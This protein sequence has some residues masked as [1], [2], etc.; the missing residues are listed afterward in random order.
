[1]SGRYE[2]VYVKSFLNTVICL[3]DWGAKVNWAEMP[4]S[5]DLP[6]SRAKL[7]STFARA[8]Y[9]HMLMVDSDMGWAAED[10][11]RLLMLKREFV[12]GIGPKKTNPLEPQQ[13]AFSMGAAVFGQ[14]ITVTP[15][16]ATGLLEI[17]EIG[18]AF[19]LITKNVA[20]RMRDFYEGLV[21]IHEGQEHVAVFDPIVEG[22]RRL[23]EDYAFCHRWTSIG[24]H[25]HVLPDIRLKHVGS[26][27]WEGALID[28]LT[29]ESQAL[30]AAAQ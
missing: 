22:R 28:E 27:T 11:G 29:G 17:P 24:G 12:A 21:F 6:L 9:T 18:M 4:Y 15:E 8:P 14:A 5:A 16:R 2:R 13:F 25:I 10:V 20:E 3:R 26:H 7:L 19:V 23:P 1:M 30:N